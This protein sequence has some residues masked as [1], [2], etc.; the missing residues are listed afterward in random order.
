MERQAVKLEQ[1]AEDKMATDFWEYLD[2]LIANSQV[3]IDRPQGSAHPRYPEM[4]YPLDYGYLEGTLAMDGAG[5]DVWVGSQGGR[6]PGAVICTVD[7]NK[8][9]AEVKLL[10]GCSDEEVQAVLDFLNDGGMRALLVRRA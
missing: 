5:V 1:V 9:D 3:V 8:R 2:Q 6:S 4:I 7:L 10:L